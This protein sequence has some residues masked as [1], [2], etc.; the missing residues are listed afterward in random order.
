MNDGKPHALIVLDENASHVTIDVLKYVRAANNTIHLYPTSVALVALV[1]HRAA[2]GRLRLR[3][4]Q[5]ARS[6]PDTLTTLLT[7][8]EERKAEDAGER[9]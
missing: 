4:L 3:H 8:E 5:A 7:T 6:R 1:A 2:P 9:Q